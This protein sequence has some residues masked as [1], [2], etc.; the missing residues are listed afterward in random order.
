MVNWFLA[1]ANTFLFNCLKVELNGTL[2]IIYRVNTWIMHMC[3][4]I[5][6]GI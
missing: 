4:V 2:N 3:N 5:D 1:L 6:Y